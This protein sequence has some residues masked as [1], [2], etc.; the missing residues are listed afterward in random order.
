MYFNWDYLII[1]WTCLH[2]RW[3]GCFVHGI[4]PRSDYIQAARSPIAMCVLMSNLT[5]SV[6]WSSFIKDI[7]DSRLPHVIQRRQSKRKGAGAECSCRRC[8]PRN[9]ILQC[10]L[11][12]ELSCQATPQRKVD[13]HQLVVQLVGLYFMKNFVSGV[14]LELIDWLHRFTTNH[15]NN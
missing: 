10:L 15:I 6:C 11:K 1:A 5:N 2:S 12:P 7:P 3:F 13:V 4:S 9:C 8:S 14:S